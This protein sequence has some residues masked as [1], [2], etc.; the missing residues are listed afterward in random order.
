M[1][2]LILSTTDLRKAAHS[3]PHQFV[4]YLS[5]RHEITAIC[6]NAW[7]LIGRRKNNLYNHEFNENV[8]IVYLT[9]RKKSPALQEI[10]SSIR[11]SYF[12]DSKYCN[13]DVYIDFDSIFSGYFLAKK[14][15]QKRIPIVFDIDDDIPEMIKTSMNVPFPLKHIGGFVGKFFLE[16]NVRIADKITYTL[17]SLR[18]SYNI[19]QIKSKFIP[20][21]VDI[22]M[23]RSYPSE[24]LREI[25]GI[26]QDLVIGYVGVLREWVDLEPV[27]SAI[28]TLDI[29]LKLVIVGEEGRFKENEDLVKEYGISEKVLFVGTVPY[30]QVPKYISIMDICLI[31][32]KISP[33]T[34]H[35]LPLKLFEYMACEKPVIS[36]PLSGIKNTAGNLLFYASNAEDLKRIILELYHNDYLRFKFGKRGRKFVEENYSWD[37]ICHDFEKVLIETVRNG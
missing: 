25:L 20:N 31:P 15:K 13:F 21:G 19:P 29:P 12:M 27:F 35:A 34:E 16:K 24:Q 1:R 37:K 36:T 7:W 33:V 11:F 30:S 3:R 5:K 4:E 17:G 18:D 32:F 6:I 2:I 9:E 28:R 14:I 8:R 22:Q 23:F 26:N 10:T